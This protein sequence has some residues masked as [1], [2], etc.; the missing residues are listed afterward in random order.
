MTGTTRVAA[1]C[2]IVQD[3]SVLLAHWNVHGGQGWTLPGGGIEF[4]E[5]PVDAAVREAVEE[6]GY[7]V[8]IDAML[9]VDSILIPGARRIDGSR[10][11][12]HGLRMLYAATVVD[13]ELHR[14]VGGSTDE[15]R[16]FPLAGLPADRVGLVDAALARW[17]ALSPPGEVES[18]GDPD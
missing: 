14:E 2:V 16:W 1:Y 10:V 3:E 8:R 12:M 17:R 18:R 4:G 13:G 5:D 15:A 11:P 6:T 9:G 7:R